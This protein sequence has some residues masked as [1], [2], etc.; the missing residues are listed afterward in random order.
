MSD[1]CKP[2][3]QYQPFSPAVNRSKVVLKIILRYGCSPVNLLDILRTP[4]ANGILNAP[5]YRHC[6]LSDL[7]CKY[8]WSAYIH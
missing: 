7:L 1:A 5:K 4:F 3:N 6:M 2:L 8:G